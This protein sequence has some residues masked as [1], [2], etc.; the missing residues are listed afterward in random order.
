MVASS[1]IVGD[2][3][4]NLADIAP[5]ATVLFGI[6]LRKRKLQGFPYQLRAVEG[7]ITFGIGAGLGVTAVTQILWNSIRGIMSEI[8]AIERSIG[9]AF[10]PHEAV[11]IDQR[12]FWPLM[13]LMG[14]SVVAS[15]LTARFQITVGKE[16]GEA[17]L[18]ADGRETWSDGM[19]E[20]AGLIG[21]FIVQILHWRMAEYLLGV[22]VSVLVMRTAWE[23]LKP[24]LDV[25]LNRSLGAEIEAKVSEAILAIPG[26]DR[27]ESTKS[28]R[29]GSTAVYVLRFD[30]SVAASRLASL[31]TAIYHKV[32]SLLLDEK[33]AGIRDVD[34]HLV[35][36]TAVI[37]SVRTAYFGQKMGEWEVTTL[38]R[39]TH[40][41]VADSRQGDY[42]MGRLH[43]YPILVQDGESR[44]DAIAKM[45]Q[46]K[47]IRSL[48]VLTEDRQSEDIVR[49]LERTGGSC[50]ATT[51]YFRD[52]YIDLG[53]KK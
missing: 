30:T 2:G 22:F 35:P 6:W 24:S 27:I 8:P 15:I 19:V 34:I 49:I 16:T 38:A 28:F 47:H 11:H 41:F 5:A 42:S 33:E 31:R 14:G 40:L 1:M 7:W 13:L 46:S 4:H 52:P 3:K 36:K 23:I 37:A 45:L 50:I 10:A 48:R 9:R 12:L 26:V 21:A 32:E 25:V 18:E 20:A 29:I 53:K 51:T 17:A 43:A 44:T 39:A